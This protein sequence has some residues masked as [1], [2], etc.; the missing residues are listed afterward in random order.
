MELEES[1]KRF[2]AIVALLVEAGA[3]LLI[4]VGALEALVEL[5]RPSRRAEWRE[6]F[7]RRG[8]WQRFARWL[9]LALEFEVAADIVRTAIAPTWNQIGQLG[10]IAAI[11]TGL[12]YFLERDVE[13]AAELQRAELDGPPPSSPAP[14]A[15]IASERSRR[16]AHEPSQRSKHVPA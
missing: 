6:P 5:F 1:F 2:A 11:R 12:N 8:V 9:I 13:H 7:H 3:V 14:E 15:T 4:L 16:D 10:A